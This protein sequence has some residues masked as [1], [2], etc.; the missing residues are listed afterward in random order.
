MRQRDYTADPSPDIDFGP[1][2]VRLVTPTHRVLRW[3]LEDLGYDVY[4]SQD[5]LTVLVRLV[6]WHGDADDNEHYEYAEGYGRDFDHALA[7]A[8]GWRSQPFYG[9]FGLKDYPG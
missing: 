9:G 3:F 2:W 4:T 6:S 1:G 8:W 5:S 7:M